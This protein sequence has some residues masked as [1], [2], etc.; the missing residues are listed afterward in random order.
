[1]KAPFV[2]ATLR[3]TAALVWLL[4]YP[5]YQTGLHLVKQI[6]P[7]RTL[8]VAL[9]GVA[10]AVAGAAVV[11]ALWGA[12][13]PGLRSRVG[14]LLDHAFFAVICASVAL[15]GIAV[16]Y[17]TPGASPGWAKALAAG[18]AAALYLI[19]LSK[20][21]EGRSQSVGALAALALGVAALPVLALPLVVWSAATDDPRLPAAVAPPASPVRP[22]A[23]RRI[24]LLTF[25]GL[26][27]A[28]VRLDGKPGLT[29]HL[30]GLAREADRYERALAGGDQTKVCVPVILTGLRPPQIFPHLPSAYGVFRPGSVT[31]LAGHLKAA[32][33]RTTFSTVVV[34]PR[35]FGMGHEYVAG[36]DSAG[37]LHVASPDGPQPFLP[38]GEAAR[39]MRWR[40]A[41]GPAPSPDALSF[42]RN[43]IT[44]NERV[45]Q[46]G[47]A[48]LRTDTPV[49]LWLHSFVP[50]SPFLEVPA[51]RLA[52]PHDVKSYRRV[53][54]R[55][56]A[57]AMHDPA[58][59]A[60]IKRVHDTFV[61]YG[62]DTYGRFERALRA[63]GLWDDTLLIVTA[64]H[65]ESFIPG[66]LYHASGHLAEET[67]T[68]PFLLKPPG[69]RPGQGRLLP[70]LVGQEDVVPTV[71][72]AVFGTVPSGLPGRDLGQGPPPA[73]R[74]LLAW[75]P[76]DDQVGRRYRQAAAYRGRYKLLRTADGHTAL[77]DLAADPQATR[78]VSA[79]QPAV[80]AELDAW[81]RAQAPQ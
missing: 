56:M 71:L 29:P 52:G 81:L 41:K 75:A 70:G 2:Q 36:R 24:V 22:D 53:T 63:E 28:A 49:F 7:V 73:D 23:P 77:Y 26:S 27:G 8:G 60:D 11:A 80:A 30:A 79:T 5:L 65:G 48:Y 9:A 13:G 61:R 44:Y 31:G 74:T 10:L 37:G 59:L 19:Y 40:F 46:D 64:D 21:A 58:K 25:D 55:E 34:S 1:M 18:F 54:A 16:T 3:L 76:P 47:L 43:A 6:G 4:A 20:P 42:Q 66:Q 45:F 78:D 17:T 32:G 38:L 39:W 62:D 35:S 50:H 14:R 57:D 51:D 12:V 67:V 68:V 33:Y 15:L 72:G 69:R